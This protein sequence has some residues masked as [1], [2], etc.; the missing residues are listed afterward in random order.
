MVYS[1]VYDRNGRLWVGHDNGL[2]CLDGSGWK[3][4]TEAD[5]LPDRIVKALKETRAGELWIGTNNGAIRLSGSSPRPVTSAPVLT[6][7]NGLL[8]SLVFAIGEDRE[9]GIWF[10]NYAA[11]D[12]GL[13][14]LQD[15]RWQHWTPKEGLPH[16]NVTSLMLDGEGRIWAG[17]G[18]MDRGG[19]AIFSGKN[20]AW[21]IDKILPPDELAGIK[22]RSL[23]Q[24]SR[25]RVWIGSEND[26]MAIRY[27]DKTI[28]I[29][30]TENGLAN[31][32]V[33][34]TGW[35]HLDG[36]D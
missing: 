34:V 6:S 33:L 4:F 18:F 29:L 24:D 31:Q 11:P 16:A 36:N 13:N 9:G 8:H 35:G 23:F 2:S 14:R 21:H 25:G 7:P 15:G 17:C 5:G 20:G 27:G 22:V 10:G 26:G 1:L 32:E 19:A 12:G 30:T 3:T 28:K